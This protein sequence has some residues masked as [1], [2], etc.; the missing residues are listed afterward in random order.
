ME[1][2]LYCVKCKKKTDTM[3][4]H[5]STTINNRKIKKGKCKICG[6]SKSSFIK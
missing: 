4:S 6:I 5:I 2:K 1:S 3:D